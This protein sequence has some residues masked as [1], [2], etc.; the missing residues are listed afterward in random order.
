MATYAA[1]RHIELDKVGYSKKRVR[2]PSSEILNVICT[3]PSAGKTNGHHSYTPRRSSQH[4]DSFNRLF[5]T[6]EMKKIT[7]RRGSLTN[8]DV[9][10]RN[11]VTGNG[12]TSWDDRPSSRNSSPRIHTERNPVTGETYTIVSPITTPTKPVQ[13]GFAKMNGTSTPIQNGNSTPLMNGN[14]TPNGKA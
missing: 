9:T 13:N 11:P 12:V 5:G 3:P 8:Q 6:P 14:P 7:P 4:V 10:N 2:N 1:Y